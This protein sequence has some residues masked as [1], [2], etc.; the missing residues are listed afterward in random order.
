MLE[1]DD[2]EHQV[3]KP[4]RSTFRQIVEAFVA[5]DFQ[6]RDRRIDDV[7]PVDAGTAMHI[8]DNIS[9]YGEALAPLDDAVWERSIYRWMDGY[10]LMLVDPTTAGEAVSDLALHAE[11]HENASLR[12]RINSVH[13]PRTLG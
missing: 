1:K 6:L 12:L 7:A 10:W 9:S 13:I 3:P 8:A 2:A 5:G 11:L 4:W